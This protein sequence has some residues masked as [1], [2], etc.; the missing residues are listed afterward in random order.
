MYIYIYI[1]ISIYLSVY[2]YLFIYIYIVL[3]YIRV[4]PIPESVPSLQ[5][6]LAHRT[7]YRR[8]VQQ[9][10]RRVRVDRWTVCLMLLEHSFH[11]LIIN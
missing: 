2:T 1:Y 8:V 7:D 10:L 3:I 6:L 5:Q 4:N 11:A 9:S